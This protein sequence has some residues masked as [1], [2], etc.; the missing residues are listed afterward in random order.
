MIEL[1]SYSTFYIPAYVTDRYLIISQISKLIL[2]HEDATSFYFSFVRIL[3]YF[4]PRYTCDLAKKKGL[5]GKEG[6]RYQLHIVR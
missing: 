4:S 3:F 6:D 2:E 5:V 1:L